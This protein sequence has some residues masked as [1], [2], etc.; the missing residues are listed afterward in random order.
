M[1]GELMTVFGIGFAFN[2]ATIILY[3]AKIAEDSGQSIVRL[4]CIQLP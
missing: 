1:K 3:M 2:I 4:I